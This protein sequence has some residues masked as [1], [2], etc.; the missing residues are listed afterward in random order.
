MRLL[1]NH[2]WP[3][4]VRELEN[5]LEHALVLSRGGAIRAAHL[6]PEVPAVGVRRGPGAG[7]D[8]PRHS[9]QEKILLAEALRA[10]GWNRSR[11]PGGWASTAPPCG[12]RSGNTDSNPR[13]EPGRSVTM[14]AENGNG[15]GDRLRAD[16]GAG[17]GGRS[18]AW[19]PGTPAG[20]TRNTRRSA[21]AKRPCWPPRKRTRGS[22]RR[23]GASRPRAGSKPSWRC[24]R[25]W[26]SWRRTL[27]AASGQ[28]ARPTGRRQ[29]AGGV[30]DLLRAGQHRLGPGADLRGLLDRPQRG[31]AGAM[32]MGP[33][34]YVVHLPSGLSMTWLGAGPGRRCGRGLPGGGP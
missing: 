9:D 16:R 7:K 24:A 19:A 12:A 2:A 13:I 26:H 11:R 5:A 33:G 8:V 32:G 29:R 17:L 20:S 6:P 30:K 28:F 22:G 15:A 31:P 18:W 1:M 10:A 4:N 23:P 14:E 3:G 34:E 27:A 25:N 21:T